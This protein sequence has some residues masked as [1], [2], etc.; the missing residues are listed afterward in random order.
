MS[1]E[2]IRVRIKTMGS[3]DRIIGRINNYGKI[4]IK[5]LKKYGDIALEKLKEATPK[6]TGLTSESWSYDIT[7]LPNTIKL[8]FRNSNIVDGYPIAVLI[9]YGHAT[10][11]GGWVEG[12]DYINPVMNKIFEDLKNELV[13]QTNEL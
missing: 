12:T 6:D 1:N 8:V 3:I 11:N 5:L 13:S 10:R 9:Q 2:P 4:D 7:Q